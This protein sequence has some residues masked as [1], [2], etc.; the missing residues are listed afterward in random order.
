VR[1]VEARQPAGLA[2]GEVDRAGRIG[3]RPGEPDLGRRAAAELQHET[4][5]AF[6]ARHRE[7]RIDAA[8]EPVARIGDDAE[9]SSRLRDVERVP[10]RRFDQHVRGVLV[11]AR[12]LAAHDAADGLD[13]GIVRD[14]HVA[15][16]EAVGAPVEGQHLLARLGAAHH[17]VPLHL[18]GVEHV[19]RPAAVE[20]RSW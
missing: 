16:V 15:L 19:Q 18:R 14:D 11:A 8:L 17:E 20:V 4:G 1:N 9:L 6:E 13:A 12:V 3:H 5:R 2:P 7:G 10:E